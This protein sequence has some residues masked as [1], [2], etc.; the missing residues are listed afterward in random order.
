MKWYNS[1]DN[2]Y[3]KNVFGLET[4][5]SPEPDCAKGLLLL[6]TSK[7]RFDGGKLKIIE[8]L[9][10]KNSVYIKWSAGGISVESNWKRCT[11]TNIWSR[12][13]VLKNIS[14][15]QI[16]V[17]RAFSR[18]SF[19]NSEYEIYTQRSQWLNEN[20]G[21]WQRLHA[22]IVEINS[23]GGRTCISASPFL[24]LRE[25]E[26]KTG[27]AFHIVPKGNWVIRATDTGADFDIE[28]G[29]C[30]KNLRLTL[31]AG[32]SIDLP[33]ILICP[34]TDG[35]PHMAAPLLH[36]YLL[37]NHLKNHRD[38]APVIYNTWFND[39]DNIDVDDLKQQLLTA[40]NLGCEVF[41]I[42][43]GWYGTGTEWYSEAGFWQ[44][45]QNAAFFGKMKEF[46]DCVRAEGLGFGLW[47]EP[48]RVGEKAPV[49]A[50][51]P[52]WLKESGNGFYYYDLSN[53][54]AKNYI[55]NEICR[56]IE[57]YSL[58][59]MKMDYNF[60]F[61]YDESGKE[62]WGYYDAW[63][64]ILRSLKGKY[65][66]VF[67]EAC[68]SG[69]MR[70]D[71]NT[72]AHSDSHFL[73]D[74][75]NPTDVIRINEGAL[76]RHAPGYIGKWAVLRNPG[77]IARKYSEPF[78]QKTERFVTPCG[79]TWDKVEACSVDFAMKACMTGMLGISSDI[80]GLPEYAKQEM[81]KWIAYYK[82]KR[83]F[84]TRSVA[85]LLTPPQLRLNRQGWSAVQLQNPEDTSS[86]IFAYR[87][88]GGAM[89]KRLY[90][91][92]LGKDKEYTVSSVDKVE[93]EYCKTGMELMEEGIVI[94]IEKGFEALIYEIKVV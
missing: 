12:K 33:E 4:A 5:F 88:E 58:S 11:K 1:N 56:L 94:K 18:F 65:P 57:E 35:S 42:D 66:H 73:S 22:G 89:Q 31:E 80:A 6:D 9:V 50:E 16:T 83:R 51:H 86:I 25:H 39:F 82:E 15:E 40:K 59:W 20:Q 21:A 7:G 77:A 63:Y 8:K 43:A 23:Y 2:I 45:K 48:E 52:E 60:D 67:F 47:M 91:K 54:E 38:Y 79:A 55:Y 87:L 85:H 46:S 10:D 90:P 44:E 30:D 75:V 74:T 27:V 93:T 28:L 53:D 41:V 19:I 32:Q 29:L 76:L 62:F 49:A 17:F 3:L 26:G 81:K 84:I 78:G 70:H 14:N 13:D 34:L 36:E 61:G 24:C 64:E 68:A 72:L 69:G 37:K 71:I 92:C